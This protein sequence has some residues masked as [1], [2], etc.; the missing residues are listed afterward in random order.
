MLLFPSFTLL[1]LVGPHAALALH[2]EVH[3]VYKALEPVASDTGVPLTATTTYY[4]C[5][6]DLDVL[7]VPDG[8]VADAMRDPAV[9]KFLTD[10]SPRAKFVTSVRTGSL[11]LA[12]AGLL[13]VYRATSHWLSLEDLRMFD[14][15]VIEERVVIDRN[16]MT[17]G[18]VTAGVDFGLVLLSHLRGEETGKRQQLML[19]Y[20][21]QP[22]FDAGE[23]S[24]AGPELVMQVRTLMRPLGDKIAPFAL[25]VAQ[26]ERNA[27]LRVRN[28]QF[29]AGRMAS[30]ASE[31]RDSTSGRRPPRGSLERPRSVAACS[32]PRDRRDA[33]V[34]LTS[35]DV[36]AHESV[37]RLPLLALRMQAVALCPLRRSR[38]GWRS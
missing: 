11:V 19:E 24:S 18:G 20:A 21:P 33:R 38:F 27:A 36:A 15:N 13:N 26:H 6:L 25:A 9:L 37:A 3:L 31:A 30:R 17:G 23:P 22:P 7:F 5:P 14:V 2:G 28:G 1:D 34:L 4:D 10:R 12:A 35:S 29:P 16:R 32:A 8:F